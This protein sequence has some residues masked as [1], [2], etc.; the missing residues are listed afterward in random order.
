MCFDR[1]RERKLYEKGLEKLREDTDPFEVAKNVKKLMTLM[2]SM[3]LLNEQREMKLRHTHDKLLSLDSGEV[4]QKVSLNPVLPEKYYQLIEQ[5]LDY[6]ILQ[7]T[8][9]EHLNLTDVIVEDENKDQ[10]I[11]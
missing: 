3:D 1:P 11:K 8:D 4:K 5:N 9:Q 6:M 2:E 10:E 7:K